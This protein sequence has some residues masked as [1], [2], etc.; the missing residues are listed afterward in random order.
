MLALITGCFGKDGV[1][2]LVMSFD[3]FG[4]Q[5]NYSY[6]ILNVIEFLSYALNTFKKFDDILTQGE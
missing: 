4:G 2:Y 3:I 5:T 1:L 6:D